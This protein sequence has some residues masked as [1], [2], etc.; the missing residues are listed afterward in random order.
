MID[1]IERSDHLE[2]MYSLSCSSHSSRIFA[3]KLVQVHWS[4]VGRPRKWIVAVPSD[5]TPNLGNAVFVNVTS[6]TEG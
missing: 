6:C 4:Q 2:R 5:S 1:K 3:E